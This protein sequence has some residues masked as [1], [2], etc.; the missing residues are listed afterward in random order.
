M[1]DGLKRAWWRR[2]LADPAYAY[3]G[4]PYDGDELVSLDFETTGLDI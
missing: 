4:E 1:L 3:I 2:R